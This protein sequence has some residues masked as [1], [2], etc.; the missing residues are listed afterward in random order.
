MLLEMSSVWKLRSQAAGN[1]AV[2]QEKLD[3]QILSNMILKYRNFSSY[4][5]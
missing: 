2:Y 4:S 3:K 5:D 1:I